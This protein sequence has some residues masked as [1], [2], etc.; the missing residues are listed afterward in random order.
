[1][2][3]VQCK[4]VNNQ[5][6]LE[7]KLKQ[8]IIENSTTKKVTLLFQIVDGAI[9]KCGSKAYRLDSRFRLYT[10]KDGVASSFGAKKRFGNGYT[11]I[12]IP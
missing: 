9:M 4:G 1:M 5:L 10:N 7:Q 3:N 8:D 11:V 6:A 2:I 12:N